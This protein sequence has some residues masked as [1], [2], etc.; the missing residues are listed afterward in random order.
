M[1]IL[2][3]SHTYL[4][5]DFVVGSHQLAAALVRR[6]HDVLHV[7]TPLSPAHAARLADR[8]IRQR[9]ALL[10]LGERA[11]GATPV[12]QAVP[13]SLLPA[14]PPFVSA[15]RNLALTTML[16]SLPRLLRAAGMDAPDLA[17]VDQPMFAG[18]R[19][20]VRPRVLLYRPTD[21]YPEMMGDARVL[22]I[23]RALLAEAD[24]VI[25]ASAPV[26]RRMAELAPDRPR[27]VLENGVEFG[28]FAEPADPPAEYAGIRGPRVVYVGALD[29]RFDTPAVARAAAALPDVQFLLIGPVDGQRAAAGNVHYLG[30][31]PY[32]RLPAYLQHADAG[33]LPLSDHPANRGRSPMKLYEYLAAGLGVVCRRTPETDAR[34][35]P[36]VRTYDDPAA[37]APAIRGVLDA[38]VAREAARA[39]A[40]S[41][42]WEDRAERLLAFAREL[43]G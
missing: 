17:L 40:R 41:R 9:F 42:S 34:A 16:P 25:S 2:F 26:D 36:E 39:R 20:R 43:G 4:G 7:S 12:R 1:K 28:F 18:L 14:R 13:F 5:G 22:G 15:R 38:P 33:I 19:R 21:L 10:G 11:Q 6:G 31:R 37:L 24:G 32:A 29:G 27:L 23:E 8:R 35:L 3:A 30:R